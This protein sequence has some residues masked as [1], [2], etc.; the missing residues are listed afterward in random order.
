VLVTCGR[1]L[2]AASCSH[3]SSL[4]YGQIPHPARPLVNRRVSA[5]GYSQK[6]MKTNSLPKM[7]SHSPASQSVHRTSNSAN[8]RKPNALILN[9][10]DSAWDYYQSVTP[11]NLSP[12]VYGPTTLYGRDTIAVVNSTCGAGCS[13]VGF[14]G[15]EIVT[16]YFDLLYNGY[17]FQRQFDQ[18][19]FYEF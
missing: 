1:C 7:D 12:T 8:Y 14:T 2:G 5:H 6:S 10:L 17:R 4:S 18:V 11:T 15:N 19:M 16:N 3:S 9:A 13:Y